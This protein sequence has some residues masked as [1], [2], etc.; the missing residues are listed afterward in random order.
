MKLLSFPQLSEGLP[1]MVTESEDST[2]S[3]HRHSFFEFAYVVSGRAEHLFKGNTAIVEAG[4]YF[5]VNLN[6]A[7]AFRQIPGEQDFRVINCIFLPRFLDPSLSEAKSFPDILE[8]Y[9]ARFGYDRSYEPL[10]RRIFRDETGSVGFLCQEI[11][12]EYRE[13]Q[14]GY[15]EVIR[16]HLLTLIL[17]L[18]RN[19][20]PAETDTVKGTV[21]RIKEYVAEHYASSLSLSHIC[22]HLNFSL[23]YVSTL[24]RNETGMTFRSYLIRYRIEAS[25]RLLR[26]SRMTVEEI[27][28]HVGYDEP[29]FFYKSFR[30]IMGLTPKEYRRQHAKEPLAH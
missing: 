30:K 1:F 8:A 26:R 9:L 25:C 14:T 2:V 19:E 5:L 24:F 13:K 21:L 29:A 18:V 11:V 7:H 20:A 6:S 10:T 3:E 23:S 4:N 28:R 16:N 27:A 17:Y 22:R 15:E 12:R